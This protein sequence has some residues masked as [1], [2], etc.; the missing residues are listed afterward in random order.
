[1]GGAGLCVRVE[2]DL[3]RRFFIRVQIFCC[4]EQRLTI[5]GG[6]IAR[7]NVASADV[8]RTSVCERGAFPT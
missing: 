5:S 1:M 2:V 4:K 6:D 3:L 7:R 8:L